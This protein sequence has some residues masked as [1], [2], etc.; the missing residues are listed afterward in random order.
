MK[1]FLYF[2]KNS[3]YTGRAGYARHIPPIAQLREKPNRD[4]TDPDLAFG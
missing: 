2:W 1:V 3:C 4:S